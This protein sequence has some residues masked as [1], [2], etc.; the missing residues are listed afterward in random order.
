[1]KVTAT[2]QD[3]NFFKPGKSHAVSLWKLVT[4]TAN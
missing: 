2:Q 4:F 1:M 3:Y